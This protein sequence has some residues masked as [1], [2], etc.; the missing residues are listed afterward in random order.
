MIALTIE[1]GPL[2]TIVR[3]G[4]QERQGCGLLGSIRKWILKDAERELPQLLPS[5][6]GPP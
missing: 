3:T 6:K 2:I 4:M 5:Q 1:A